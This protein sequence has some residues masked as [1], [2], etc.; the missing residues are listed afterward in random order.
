MMGAFGAALKT[1]IVRAAGNIFAANCE[2][3]MKIDL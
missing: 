2:R 1:I 3:G